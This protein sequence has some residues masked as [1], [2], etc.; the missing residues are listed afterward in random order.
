MELPESIKAQAEYAEALGAKFAGVPGE[1]KE[2]AQTEPEPKEEPKQETQAPTGE[3]VEEDAEVE[4]LRQRYSSLQGK[5]NSEVPR[6][7]AQVRELEARLQQLAEAN[8]KLQEDAAKQ[9]ASRG[10]LT[11][12][13]VASYGNEMIDFVRRGAREEMKE[14]NTFASRM[15]REVDQLKAQV[16]QNSQQAASYAT[17]TFYA[18]LSRDCPGWETQ[19]KDQEFISWLQEADP[20]LGVSRQ[21]ALNAATERLDGHRVA[22]IFNAYRTLK[23]QKSHSNPLARQVSPERS[24][25]AAP[26]AP[27]EHI[28]TQAKIAEV[29]ELARRGEITKDEFKALEQEIDAAVANGKVRP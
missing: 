18:D 29:Y 2:P 21:D 22:A 3:K 27:Q 5:Y 11:K 10:Y 4:K 26:T 28:W 23:Q 6:L 16:A 19:D 20:I 15:Q 24:T 8:Q 7:N 17:S 25:A 9:E 12:E 13:D 1:Q 14:Y